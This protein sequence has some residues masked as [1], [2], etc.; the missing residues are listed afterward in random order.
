[1][2]GV[3]NQD[4]GRCKRLDSHIESIV[5]FLCFGSTG[6]GSWCQK[7][8][9]RLIRIQM[10]FL[11]FWRR[12][13]LA[14]LCVCHHFAVSVFATLHARKIKAQAASSN[15]CFWSQPTINCLTDWL[16]HYTWAH[17]KHHSCLYQQ[18]VGGRSR[19]QHQSL[20]Q[21]LSASLSMLLFWSWLWWHAAPHFQMITGRIC[22]CIMA[23][24]TVFRR[25]VQ[26]LDPFGW[27]DSIGFHSIPLDSI[28]SP[29]PLG[30]GAEV[31][32]RKNSW[33][34]GKGDTVPR[35]WTK[36]IAWLGKSNQQIK[37]D[38]GDASFPN[39]H[40]SLST[41]TLLDHAACAGMWVGF[42]L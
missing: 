7:N 20:S 11:E 15:K 12:K 40:S 21:P 28:G 8:L 33:R 39:V 27:L 32:W 25:N 3:P 35:H 4:S 19:A 42:V 14:R 29:G 5:F 41:A 38:A 17:L 2:P 23:G 22:S 24:P 9:K 34:P 10:I 26:R 31:C 1:M 6:A 13:A 36:L 18:E 16:A 37:G 30:V